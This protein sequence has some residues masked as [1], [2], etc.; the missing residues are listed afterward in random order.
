MYMSSESYVI[1]VIYNDWL[2]LYAIWLI[3]T[4]LFHEEHGLFLS[5]RLL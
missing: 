4:L 3:Y 2:V 5:H 1:W